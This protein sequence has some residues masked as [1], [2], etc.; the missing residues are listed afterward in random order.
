MQCAEQCEVLEKTSLIQ[1]GE[2][3]LPLT[4][5]KLEKVKGK[6][7]MMIVHQGYMHYNVSFTPVLLLG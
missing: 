3:H 6:N 2:T 7:D 4:T 1:P 5:M